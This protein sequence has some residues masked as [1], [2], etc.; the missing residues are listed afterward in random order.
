MDQNSNRYNAEYY[1]SHC[2][3]NYERNNGWEEVF[4]HIAKCI[5][6]GLEIH[7]A[8]DVG[9]ATGYLVESFHKFGVAAEGIDISEYALSCVKEEMKDFCYRQ[10]I[11]EPL[12]KKYDLISC[13]EVLEH[14]RPEEISLAIE[15]ICNATDLVIFS[16]TPFDYD[17]ETHFSVH[18]VDY[19]AEQFA[20]QG[21]YHD[22][23]FDCAFISVQAMLFR[24]GEKSKID[25]IR[26]YE[27]ILFQKTQETNSM[28][29]HRDLNHQKMVLAENRNEEL[30]RT[31]SVERKNHQEELEMIK[32]EQE[33]VLRGKELEHA[34]EMAECEKRLR[35]AYAKE[36]EKR[37]FY[38]DKYQTNKKEH[39]E[40]EFYRLLTVQMRQTINLKITPGIWTMSLTAF[41]FEKIRRYRESRQ[42][43]R[44]NL[45]WSVVFDPEYYARS[46]PDVMRAY[47]NNKA[48]LLKHFIFYGTCEARQA[49][50]TFN[51]YVYIESNPDIVEILKDNIRGYYLHYIS[52]GSK[53]GRRA[54]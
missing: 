51:V 15:N 35:D 25:L 32:K 50:E 9:C 45:D 7:T 53:E 37:L 23:K 41:C 28:R 29:H 17:E 47:G 44:Q 31:L 21:F 2:G 4:D 3:K 36:V 27:S 14:L 30:E 6:S 46:N 10:S 24:R 5:T 42:L 1:S 33:E 26:D 40:L 8:M 12:A 19:W 20:Y 38:E 49:K 52:E 34:N 54:I 18:S 48:S 11:T 13:I 43:I 16:S 39:D 22:V